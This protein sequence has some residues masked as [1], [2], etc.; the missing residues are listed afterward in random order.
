[1]PLPT[2]P[3]ATFIDQ[4]A[5]GRISPARYQ[6]INLGIA[7]HL[8]A[9]PVGRLPQE[10]LSIIF[11]VF[12]DMSGH[13]HR[14][15]LVLLLVCWRWYTT[16]RQ[17]SSLWTV[18]YFPPDSKLTT[19]KPTWNLSA[20]RMQWKRRLA[21]AGTLN[22]FAHFAAPSREAVFTVLTNEHPEHVAGFVVQGQRANLV[23]RLIQKLPLMTN[24]NHISVDLNSWSYT[25]APTDQLIH[26]SPCL[27]IAILKGF[28]FGLAEVRAFTDAAPSLQELTLQSCLMPNLSTAGAEPILLP[29]LKRLVLE[30]SALDRLGFT[31]ALHA[32]L[33]KELELI[34]ANVDV[35]QAREILSLELVRTRR[36]G[37]TISLSLQTIVAPQFC[38]QRHGSAITWPLVRFQ[39]ESGCGERLIIGLMIAV[40]AIPA[41]FT[42]T[43]IGLVPV[44][45]SHV[46][47][48]LVETAGLDGVAWGELEGVP[49][50]DILSRLPSVRRMGFRKVS[51]G[52]EGTR[53]WLSSDLTM[54]EEIALDHQ[55]GLPASCLVW[56]ASLK[57]QFSVFEEKIKDGWY[58]KLWTRLA[59]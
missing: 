11:S 17:T 42:A 12:A 26:Q 44:W 13:C 34:I 28:V 18:V 58:S 46:Q 54:L 40:D 33:L 14:D 27:S 30:D 31:R 25:G 39:S 6:Q 57:K 43:V 4:P 41:S 24:L 22:V 23:R 2:L 51:G 29:C 55:G 7:K 35:T 16:A 10:I 49:W 38:G 47:E 53:Q 8:V 52:W 50:A 1:M 48:L 20:A 36:V 56:V 3:P 37:S 15:L 9:S 21:M 32:P 59:N 45:P 5:S 19:A